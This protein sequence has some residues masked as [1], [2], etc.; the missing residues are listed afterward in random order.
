[1]RLLLPV[2]LRLPGLR[3]CRP[4]PRRRAIFSIPARNIR[5]LRVQHFRQIARRQLNIQPALAAGNIDGV[6]FL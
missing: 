5:K 1:V 3:A 2:A 6:K 4:V